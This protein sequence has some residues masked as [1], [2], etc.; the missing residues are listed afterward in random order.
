VIFIDSATPAFNAMFPT[1]PNWSN[2]ETEVSK[3]LSTF[4]DFA[5]KSGWSVVITRHE[6]KTGGT[7]GSVAWEYAPDFFW[8]Y[9]TLGTGRELSI[10]GRLLN[11]PSPLIIKKV[12]NRIYLEGTKKEVKQEEWERKML[13]EKEQV[14]NTIP[15]ATETEVKNGASGMTIAD[16]I[17]LFDGKIGQKRVRNYVTKLKEENQVATGH[18][19]KGKEY[20]VV[21]Y[22][23]G[24]IVFCSVV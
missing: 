1:T 8:R 9:K 15:Y 21:Y 16:L 14:L 6:N 10:T 12:D 23:P 11:T 13:L 2:Q 5:H 20:R 17:T 24:D 7:L 4:R 3:A 18:L 19:G 22:R